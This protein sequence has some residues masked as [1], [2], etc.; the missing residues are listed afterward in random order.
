M[1]RTRG[2]SRSSIP[3]HTRRR[4]RRSYKTG[5]CTRSGRSWR[6]SSSARRVCDR[7]GRLARPGSERDTV[8][9]RQRL[10]IAFDPLDRLPSSQRRG[11]AG[12]GQPRRPRHRG[13]RGDEALQDSRSTPRGDRPRLECPPTEPGPRIRLL[14]RQHGRR[15]RAGALCGEEG[16]QVRERHAFRMLPAAVARGEPRRPTGARQPARGWRG[17]LAGSGGGHAS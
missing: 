13:G 11:P 12:E 8:R 7:G 16:T 5:T 15:H 9:Q 3:W 6:A 1:A 4:S 2:R 10:G 14:H 17:R